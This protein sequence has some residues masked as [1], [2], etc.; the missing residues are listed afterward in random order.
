[1]NS[2]GLEVQQEEQEYGK[3]LC[4]SSANLQWTR[5]LHFFLLGFI[6]EYNCVCV[7]VSHIYAF[8]YARMYVFVVGYLDSFRSEF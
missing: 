5:R 4:A 1:M 8:M 3:I 7:C 2:F 6:T